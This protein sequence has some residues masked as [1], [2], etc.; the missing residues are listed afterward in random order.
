[1]LSIPKPSLQ[2][3]QHWIHRA[4]QFVAGNDRC[5]APSRF[6]QN[7]RIGP[8]MTRA[9]V[10]E[11]QRLTCQGMLVPHGFVGQTLGGP[12]WTKWRS[13]SKFWSLWSMNS[14][15]QSVGIIINSCVTHSDGFR[16]TTA[17]RHWGHSEFLCYKNAMARCCRCNLL[18][19]S[20]Y[21]NMCAV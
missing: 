10:Q 17:S 14:S 3:A 13:G 21:M 2:N 16:I 5:P 11:V 15:N 9:Q 7:L 6:P 20:P 19:F 12:R 4:D 18:H 8:K 1:M